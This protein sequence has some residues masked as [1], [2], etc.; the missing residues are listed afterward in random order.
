MLKLRNI[1][2]VLLSFAWLLAVV[3]LPALAQQTGQSILLRNVILIDREGAK[4]NVQVNL[5]IRDNLLDIVTQDTIPLEDADETFD[6][7][8]GVVLGQLKL[9]EPASFLILDDD[10]RENVD[11]LLDTKT[12]ATFAIRRGIV[13]KNTYVMVFSETP[14]ERER[15]AKG[16]LAYAPP[17]IAIPLNYRD[18]R[19]WN[20]VDGKY[21]SGLFAAAVVLDRQHWTEQD[22]NSEIQVGDLKEFDGG[23]I[24]ALRLGGVGTINFEQPWV[25]VA[26]GATHAFDKGFDTDETDDFT[27]F[28]LRLDIPLWDKASF[29]IGKQKEP[30]SMERIMSMVDMPMQ[31]RAAVSDALLP[32]RNVGLVMAGTLFDDRVTLAGG[33]FNDWLDKDQPNSFSDNAT[34]F[35]GRATWVPLVSGNESTLLHLGIGLRHSDTEQGALGKTEPEFN[36]APAY[37]ETPF[38]EAENSIV[39]QAEASLR[40]GP[41]WLHG[42]YVRAEIDSPLYG[43]PSYDGYHLTASW[44][45]TGE[46]RPYNRRVGIFDGVP[47][48][49]D[50]NQ[51]GW[52]AWELGTRFS[53]VDLSDGNQLDGSPADGGEMDIWSVGLNWWLT[54][55]MNVNINYRYITLDRFGVEGTSQGFNTR[56]ALSLE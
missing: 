3:T 41:F 45:L 25:W 42:E 26:F 48:S 14:Q 52:G 11:V 30:I 32:S 43:D 7:A 56:V 21:V 27:M 18:D 17:P 16:W 46:V 24:G 51:N 20:K 37:V 4:E 29:S 49:R 12:H 35:V 5:L 33:A 36:N 53:H 22:D 23:E 6:A 44:I 8:G 54:P 47:I 39:Y 55:V 50:V 2:I 9:G 1:K 34:Q 38:M 28:D 10:P 40:S 13:L 19:K 15:A 31:E